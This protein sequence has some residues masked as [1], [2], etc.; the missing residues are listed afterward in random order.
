[1]NKDIKIPD[2]PD[3]HGETSS[4]VFIQP[5]TKLRERVVSTKG[6]DFGF[7]VAA[8]KKAEMA[9]DKLSENFE[10]W[11]IQE[12]SHLHDTRNIA[13]SEHQ[14]A[15]SIDDFYRASH[16]LKGQ[17]AT[18][19]YPI[20]GQLCESLCRLIDAYQDKAR[21]PPLLINQHVD[22]VRALTKEKIMDDTDAKAKMLLDRIRIVTQDCINQEKKRKHDDII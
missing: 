7:D 4:C 2:L 20:I 1:M 19:G 5:V 11:L 9:L 12:V 16:D 6:N 18:L 15:S 8:I 17:A 14:S 21:I 13:L 10:E 3:H 22:A